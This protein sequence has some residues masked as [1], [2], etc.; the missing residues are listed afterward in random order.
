MKIDNAKIRMD[1]ILIAVRKSFANYSFLQTYIRGDFTV[2]LLKAREPL[3]ILN[4][5]MKFAFAVGTTVAV[6]LGFAQ[7]IGPSPYLGASDSPWNPSQFSFFHLEDLED[8]ALNTPG[9]SASAGSI[10]GPGG[11]TDS[12][13]EDSGVIDGSGSDGR[14]LFQQSGSAGVSFTFDA[15][16][17]GALP[18]HAGV[19]WTDGAGTITFEAFDANNVSLGTLTGNHADAS[20]SG[21]TAEDRF[22]GWENSAGISRIHIRNSSGGIEMDHLQYGVVPEPATMT[23]LAFGLAAAIKRRR[24]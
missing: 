11:F 20:F 5:M 19:V 10:I 24:R 13:D 2:V 14:S 8:G 15:S 18:T 21:T 9:V 7:G 16:I 12:V 3:V 17:L 23:V 4:T 6:S 1:P 22:Y